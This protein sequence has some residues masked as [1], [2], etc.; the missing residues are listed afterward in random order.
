MIILHKNLLMLHKKLY[1]FWNHKNYWNEWNEWNFKKVNMK[2][3]SEPNCAP[4]LR[5]RSVL[6]LLSSF[7]PIWERDPCLACSKAWSVGRS[8]PPRTPACTSGSPWRSKA[9]TLPQAC[10]QITHLVDSVLRDAPGRSNGGEDFLVEKLLFVGIRCEVVEEEGCGGC[11]RRCHCALHG[12]SSSIVSV[13]LKEYISFRVFKFDLK[14]LCLID[15][16]TL[17]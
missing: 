12:L 1:Y 3:H 14:M 5:F 2:Q 9:L 10:A 4:V 7:W 11:R 17:I 8:L 16:L 6:L 15:F 13:G